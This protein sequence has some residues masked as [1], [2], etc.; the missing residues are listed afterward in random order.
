MLENVGHLPDFQSIPIENVR[1]LYVRQRKKAC[2]KTIET[3][4]A[5][6]GR[7]DWQVIRGGKQRARL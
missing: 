5:D 2:L 6:E 7:V 4:A 3:A 1:S